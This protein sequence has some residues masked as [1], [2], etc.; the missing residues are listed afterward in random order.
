MHALSARAV[1]THVPKKPF[2]RVIA[3]LPPLCIKKEPSMHTVIFLSLRV[4]LQVPSIFAYRPTSKLQHSSK[5]II[6]MKRFLTSFLLL[7]ASSASAKTPVVVAPKGLSKP[8]TVLFIRGGEIDKLAIAKTA[9][10]A[11]AVHAGWCAMAPQKAINAYGIK[12]PSSI[13]NFITTRSSTVLSAFSIAFWCLAHKNTS[14]NTAYGISTI[15]FIVSS[16]HAILNEKPKEFGYSAAVECFNIALFS[17]AVQAA[18]TDSAHADT[19]IKIVLG[20]GLFNG[21]LLFAN[22]Q[23]F[24]KLYNTPEREAVVY[25]VSRT[26]GNNLIAF[27][28]YLGSLV[29]GKENLTACAYSF[30]GWALGIAIQVF[31]TKDIEQFDHFPM[32]LTYAWIVTLSSL[33]FYY[34]A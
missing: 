17:M 4:F 31:M 30:I 16:V 2:L 21:A 10:I 1:R 28:V 18:L 14:I 15:P 29:L 24:G 33:G 3:G 12:N 25:S 6:T 8:A 23:L 34:L 26:Y 7:A 13:V 32:W 27:C 22:P 9:N 11:F 19:L 5:Q 20:W